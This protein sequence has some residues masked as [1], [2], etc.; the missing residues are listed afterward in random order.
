MDSDL[1]K[2][3]TYLEKESCTCV[4]CREDSLLSSRD[5]GVRP[6]LAFLDSDKEFT[7]FSAADKVVGKATA[8]LYCLLGV[9]AVHAG[10]LSDAAAAVLTQANIAF[11]CDLRVAGIRNRDNTGP[12]PMENATRDI[13]D[14]HLALTAIRDTLKAL[15]QK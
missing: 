9:R 13:S 5:R 6:L 2:A 1:E 11:S 3:K 4:L 10:V 8:F 14:P 7:G 12:C 15:Q